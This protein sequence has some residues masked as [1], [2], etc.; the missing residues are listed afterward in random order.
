V[1]HIKKECKEDM[2]GLLFRPSEI[3]GTLL[4]LVVLLLLVAKNTES[5]KK[6]LIERFGE[7]WSNKAII[8]F[9]GWPMVIVVPMM[10]LP[11]QFRM[12]VV[13]AGI[14]FVV[15]LIWRS[16]RKKGRVDNSTEGSAP[17]EGTETVK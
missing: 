15:F 16:W 13:E 6:W 2:M 1:E 7:E 11:D 10:F 12:D 8:Q 9:F 4:L 17:K 14:A 3:M 5:G